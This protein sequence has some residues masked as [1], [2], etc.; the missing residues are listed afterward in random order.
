MGRW[1]SLGSS[2]RTSSSKHLLDAWPK[3]TQNSPKLWEST[4]ASA[5]R[6]RTPKPVRMSA[7]ALWLRGITGMIPVPMAWKNTGSPGQE[8]C[9]CLYFQCFTVERFW[10]YKG[11]HSPYNPLWKRTSTESRRK[12]THSLGNIQK[13]K[14]ITFI[15]Y[16]IHLFP[17]QALSSKALFT[18]NTIKKYLRGLILHQILWWLNNTNI[19]HFGEELKVLGSVSWSDTLGSSHHFWSVFQSQCLLEASP[20]QKQL[21][22]TIHLK[23]SGI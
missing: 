15:I 2:Q 14:Q 3:K 19:S 10:K 23:T 17:G 5:T 21:H 12:Q 20:L 16:L 7:A 22:E 4:S 18:W 8:K 11:I 1:S 13:E 6:T 9:F